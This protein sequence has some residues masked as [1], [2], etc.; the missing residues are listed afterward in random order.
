[1]GFSIIEVNLANPHWEITEFYNVIIKLN[2][3]ETKKKIPPSDYLNNQHENCKKPIIDLNG[4]QI[5]RWQ[6][7]TM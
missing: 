4:L 3:L 5:G 7:F 2:S 6:N 1:M